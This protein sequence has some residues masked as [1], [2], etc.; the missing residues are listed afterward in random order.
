MP[1]ASL[2]VLKNFPLC[3][4]KAWLKIKLISRLILTAICTCNVLRFYF[5]KAMFTSALVRMETWVI[6]MAGFFHTALQPFNKL[7][8]FASHPM[9]AQAAFGNQAKA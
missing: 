2:T 6:T 4:F 8:S 1:S 9:P 5:Q 3:A 7:E